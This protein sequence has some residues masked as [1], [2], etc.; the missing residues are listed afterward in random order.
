MT[1][2]K[3]TLNL[4]ES[5]ASETFYYAYKFTNYFSLDVKYLDLFK[6]KFSLA[7]SNTY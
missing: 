5:K 7:N 1:Y 3:L 2:L 4:S 6:F